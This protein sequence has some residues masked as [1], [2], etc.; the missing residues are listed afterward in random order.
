MPLHKTNDHDESQPIIFRQGRT[1]TFFDEVNEASVGIAMRLIQIMLQESKKKPI[2]IML[3][4]P[5]GSVYDGLALYDYLMTCPA[6]TV[7]IGTGLVASM[8]VILLLAGDK[9]YL[10]KSARLMTHQI[11]TSVEGKVS[12]VKIDY[13]E[14]KA[15][16]KI[17]DSIVAER[18]KQTIKEIEKDI[19]KGDRYMSPDLALKKGYIHKIIDYKN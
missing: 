9:R 2:Q 17:C 18:T 4:T 19:R 10:T 13:E 15:L 5:G 6:P 14:T 8:G 3:N 16:E 12:D 11:A 7:I 1:L